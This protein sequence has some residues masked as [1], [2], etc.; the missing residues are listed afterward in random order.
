MAEEPG[1]LFGSKQIALRQQDGETSP[2]GFSWAW[3]AR[4]HG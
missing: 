2:T 4:G 1:A 3:R